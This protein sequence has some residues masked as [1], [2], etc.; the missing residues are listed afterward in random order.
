MRTSNPRTILA[1]ASRIAATI[2]FLA[3]GAAGA[4][5]GTSTVVYPTGIFPDDVANVQAAINL[6]GT[7]ILK[8]VNVAG[9][10]TA[11]NFGTPE[12]LP[13][14][15]VLITTDVS[16]IGEQAGTSMTT[17]QGGLEPIRCRVP[18]QITIQGIYFK[19]PMGDAI[20][21]EASTGATIIGN[22]IDAVVPRPFPTF[23]FGDGIDVSGFDDPLH[24]VTG[25]V[26]VSGNTI[27]N[28]T[29]I[30]CSAIQFD[31]VA[32]ESEIT[33]NTIENF[34]S[35]GILALRSG[36][37]PVLIANNLVV[38]GP[39]FQA[40]SSIQIDG[41]P[42]ASFLVTGNTI[43]SDNFTADG[44][45]VA[46]VFTAGTVAPVV[47]RNHITMHNSLF[48]GLSIYGQVTGAVLGEN[49][50]DGDSAF[51]M[52]I[53]EG[54][55]PTQLATSN[56]LQGNDISH[57]VPSIAD[58]Y[59]GTNTQ[60]NEVLGPCNSFIDFGTGNFVTCGRLTTGQGQGH[61]HNPQLARLQGILQQPPKIQ[62]DF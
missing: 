61:P 19:S 11:F 48:G 18:V 7:V 37:T 16:I 54:F 47:Q 43:V 49:Q 34:A 27:T 4:R 24:A 1:Y 30:C 33:G 15:R 5:V 29:A 38:L 31:S 32:A 22:R 53:A 3:I 21:I 56:R 26:V 44:I 28:L 12:F 52:Q 2:L 62:P 13:G 10:P 36:Q 39:E 46:G 50:I 60:G 57:A 40:G 14:R 45:I 25:K 51:A 42:Q 17:I 6:G 55:F 41:N 9:Q 58:I 20:D 23:T 8:A 59:L 35:I